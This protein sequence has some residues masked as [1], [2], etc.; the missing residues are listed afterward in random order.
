MVGRAGHGARWMP[1][2]LSRAGTIDVE[3]RTVLSEIGNDAWYIMKRCG[4]SYT[5][6]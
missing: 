5:T 6:R 3:V 1:A 4:F 2:V